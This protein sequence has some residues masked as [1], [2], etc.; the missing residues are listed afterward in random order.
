MLDLALTCGRCL[1]P[2]RGFATNTTDHVSMGEGLWSTLR[3]LG[4][5]RGWHWLRNARVEGRSATG[6]DQ[7]GIDLVSGRGSIFAG[8]G[9]DVVSQ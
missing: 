1:D 7:R 3:R 9:A 5:Q 4:V 8:R 6:N 2:L